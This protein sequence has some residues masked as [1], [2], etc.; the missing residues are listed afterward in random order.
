MTPEQVLEQAVNAVRLARDYTADVEFSPEDAGRSER[1]LPL[2]PAG[3]RHRRGC[4]HGQH[5]GHGRL[6][7]AR[8]VRRA[9]PHLRE[10]IPNSDKAIWSVHC[11]N[12]LGLAVANSLAARDERRAPGGVHD[13]RP[14]RARRQRSLEESRHGGAHA[15][16]TYFGLRRRAS[17]RRRSCRP[18][19]W[20]PAS[21]A[22][23]CSRTR[24]SS[25]RMRLRTRPGIHQDG[26]QG[27]ETPTR[28]CVPRTWA[29]TRTS[30][31]WASSAASVRT[32]RPNWASISRRRS[33]RCA[34]VAKFTALTATMKGQSPD[35]ALHAQL[36]HH[37]VPPVTGVPA[38]ALA[39]AGR[40]GAGAKP[41][42]QSRIALGD[43]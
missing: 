13:Q 31:C 7:D 10:R 32:R 39:H 19:S 3:S 21:P 34:A 4:H 26:V 23:R 25:A 24:P 29:G 2:P 36:F 14:G 27:R 42:A 5:S 43:G 40:V 15:R 1:R 11:H 12:D 16:A 37:G 38:A 17:T 6:Y 20:C 8:A 41:H 9:D 28:S 35:E 33:L 18:P 30:W 22:F